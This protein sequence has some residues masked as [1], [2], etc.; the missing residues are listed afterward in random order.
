M[1]KLPSE[2]V[3]GMAMTLKERQ[4]YLKTQTPPFKKGD[5]AITAYLNYTEQI[6]T[7]TKCFIAEGHCQTGWWVEAENKNGKKLSLDSAW[8]AKIQKGF[9]L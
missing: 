6:W 4:E 2:D 8:F 5:K 7:I 3:K 9:F 1:K